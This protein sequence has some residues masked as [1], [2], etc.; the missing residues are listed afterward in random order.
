MYFDFKM[1]KNPLLFSVF[2]LSV[3][4]LPVQYLNADTIHCGCSCPVG[5]IANEQACLASHSG[6]SA[7]CGG[8]CT[9]HGWII[10]Q[11]VVHGQTIVMRVPGPASGPP[12]DCGFTVVGS[13]YLPPLDP[14]LSE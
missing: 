10:V 8:T 5:M 3:F 6:N 13:N 7:Q 12:K 4:F 11:R 14:L 2:L 9:C 1:G